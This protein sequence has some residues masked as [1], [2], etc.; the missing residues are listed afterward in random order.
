MISW[1][2]PLGFL[3]FLSI[4]ALIIIYIIKPNFQKQFVSS[5]LIWKLSLKYK[6]KKVPISKLRN[7][8]IFICQV[9][10]L[11]SL[12]FMITH[13]IIAGFQEAEAVHKVLIIDASAS[14]S[15]R[16]EDGNTRF[17]RAVELARLEAQYAIN[18]RNGTVTIILAEHEPRVVANRVSAMYAV[19][20]ALNSFFILNEQTN[21]TEEATIFGNIDFDA[22]MNMARMALVGSTNG[23]ASLYTATNFLSHGDPREMDGERRAQVS[24]EVLGDFEFVYH[25]DVRIVNV[26]RGEFNVAVL[27]ASYSSGDQRFFFHPEVVSFGMSLPVR[28]FV[29][30]FGANNFA[31]GTF[32]AYEDVNL[33]NG[34]SQ[35]LYFDYFRAREGSFTNE[36]EEPIRSFSSVT[37]TITH[38]D[39]SGIIDSFPFDNSFTIYGGTKDTI[40]IQYIS[41]HTYHHDA[42]RFPL[43]GARMHFSYRW[44]FVIDIVTL[45]QF[46]QER[47][48]PNRPHTD[49]FIFEHEMPAS[50]PTDEGIVIVINPSGFD[51]RASIDRNIPENLGVRLGEDRVFFEHGAEERTRPLSNL[52][53]HP[54]TQGFHFPLQ[55]ITQSAYTQITDYYGFT[56]LFTIDD[57]SESE[58]GFP[59]VLVKN[60]L[61]TKKVIIPFNV[62]RAAFAANLNWFAM[63]DNIIEY[64]L[65]RTL[66]R[67]IFD[68]NTSVLLNA[69]SS[70]I[71]V[72]GHGLEITIDTFPHSLNVLTPGS[73]RVQQDV[74]GRH[75]QPPHRDYFF[76]R[77]PRLQSDFNREI[78]LLFHDIFYATAPPIDWDLMMY[79][80]IA[81]VALLFIERMLHIK[82]AV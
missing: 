6:K 38:Q 80:A 59:G 64:F 5:S 55:Y 48:N 25:G 26:C 53:Q 75:G 28:V 27:D 62:N 22:A 78:H 50:L 45:E 18:N 57:I 34:I 66:E 46:N 35:L 31:G 12:A 44:N 43:D 29:E 49:M 20:A 15:A 17:R 65:P 41:P 16:G 7:I 39:G 63:W 11:T 60:T 9:L 68:A 42:I 67:Y 30:V 79:F 58:D 52:I 36:R 77:I 47:T 61:D 71:T 69:R 72:A 19:N 4:L 81:L 2:I 73:Y 70:Y 3:A 76:V 51:V 23:E 54:L 32:I 37:I 8:L 40:R 33:S 74:F 13:P 24:H 82:D 14:M 21:I 1:L 10:I 56:R